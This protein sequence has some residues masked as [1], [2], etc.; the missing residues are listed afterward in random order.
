VE[1]RKNFLPLPGIKPQFEK[2]KRKR[3]QQVYTPASQVAE[4]QGE[5]KGAPYQCTCMSLIYIGFEECFV[6]FLF[7][8]KML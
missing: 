4:W 8:I 3:F 6:P 5:E 2:D 1:E 7:R